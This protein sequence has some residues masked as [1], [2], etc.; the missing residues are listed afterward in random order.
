[1][2]YEKSTFGGNKPTMKTILYTLLLMG[3][4]VLMQAQTEVSIPP[5]VNSR[6]SIIGDSTIYTAMNR[7]WLAKDEISYVSL[8]PVVSPLGDYRVPLREGEGASG[9]VQLLE[10]NLDFRFPIAMGRPSSTGF[11]RRGRF[12]FDYGANFRMMLDDSKPLT[13]WS[14]KVG[15]GFDYTLWDNYTRM[16]P[17]KDKS[18]YGAQKKLQ[19]EKKLRFLTLTIKAHHYSN[20]QP[21]GFFFDT[22][23]DGS[24][25]RRNNYQSGDFSTNYLFTQFTWAQLNTNTH[26]LWQYSL[27]YRRDGTGFPG[28][29]IFSEEQARSYGQNRLEYAIDFRSGPRKYGQRVKY[30]E[31]DGKTYY[32]DKLHEWHL[33][34]QGGVILGDLSAYQANLRND[35]GKYRFSHRVIVNYSCLKWRSFGIMAMFYYGRD[36]LNIRYDIP[37]VTAQLGFSLQL[38]K[39]YPIGWNGRTAIHKE[40]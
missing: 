30:I 3:T 37:I 31:S 34:Y 36:Y 13:P 7:S 4:A 17:W 8:A 24:P 33:R 6:Y 26:A 1:M 14:N 38:D 25:E 12:T 39:F 11:Y 5:S 10:A 23:V 18:L 21:P 20:G 32:S 15:L 40:P 29:L 35:D 22:I 28:V 27:G 19:A 9:A 16:T 2:P